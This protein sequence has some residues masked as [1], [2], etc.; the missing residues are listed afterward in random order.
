LFE[1]KE[2]LPAEAVLSLAGCLDAAIRHSMHR[3]VQEPL[4]A[5]MAYLL[6]FASETAQSLR[7]AAGVEM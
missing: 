4:D 7:S 6:W 3:A 5:D 2:G 1:I